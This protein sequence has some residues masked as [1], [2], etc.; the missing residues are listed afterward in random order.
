VTESAAI[1]R[2]HTNHDGHKWHFHYT[3]VNATPMH[4]SFT[5]VFG[6][7]GRVAEVTP[8]HGWD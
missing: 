5:V 8:I 3:N 6:P 1:E 4:V 2:L 7:D